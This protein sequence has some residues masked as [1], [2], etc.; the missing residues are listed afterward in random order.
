MKPMRWKPEKNELLK[1]ERGISFEQAVVAVEGGGLLD[2]L[3]H[4]NPEK[5]P[6]QRVMVV[7][8]D[9]YAYLV[10]FVEDEDGYLLITIIPSREA[11]RDFLRTR[12]E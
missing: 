5:Y 1:Q 11:T 6:G 2:V 9:G 4:H 12:N 3:A 10:P 8:W 7:A